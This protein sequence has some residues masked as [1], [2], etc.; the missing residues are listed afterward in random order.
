MLNNFLNNTNNWRA[1]CLCKMA[2]FC[3]NSLQDSR[4]VSLAH[5]VFK[6]IPFLLLLCSFE[7]FADVL[8]L[9][10][11]ATDDYASVMVVTSPSATGDLSA[12]D[13]YGSIVT[14]NGTTAGRYGFLQLSGSS[15]SYTYTLYDNS[16]NS[17]LAAGQVVTDIFTYTYANNVGQ[18][19]SARLIVQVTGNPPTPTVPVAVDDYASVMVGT[20]PSAT[21]NLS[22]NDRYGSIVTVNGTTAG[23]YGF[24]QLS[25][26]SGSYTYTLYNNSANSALA[27]GQVVTDT[28]TYTYANTGGQSATARLIVQV[29]GNP[30]IPVAVD[31]YAS[32]IVGTSPFLVGNLSANDLYCSIVTINGSTTGRYGFLQLTNTGGSYAYTL[33]TNSANSALAGGQVV[34]DTFTYT[35][36]NTV[37]Q[38][39]SARLIVQV[40]GP[41]TSTVPVAVDDYVTV[42]S[43]LVTTTINT[44]GSTK[45]NIGN[46]TVAGNVSTNDQNWKF[47]SLNSSPTSQ[48]GFLTGKSDGSFIYTVYNNAPGI[49]A[50]T[51]GQVVIDSFSYNAVDQYGQTATAKL[52]VT[53]IGNPVDAYGNTVFNNNP[54]DNV[55]IEPND[56]FRSATPLN[57]A[58]NIKGSL[59]RPGDKDWYLL[60]SDGNEIITVNV[61]P[62]GSSCF[63]QKNWELY[64]FDSAK[65]TDAM[66]DPYNSYVFRHWLD[67]TGSTVDLSG[68]D[69]SKTDIYGKPI[70]PSLNEAILP[71]PYFSDHMYLA[72]YAG[73]YNGA[74]IGIVDPC[75]NPSN[76]LD[77]G[78]GPGVRDFFIAI[79][80]TLQGSDDTGKPAG[81]CGI[82]RPILLK[83][84]QSV[85]G[86]D[87]STPPAS[88]LY[89][90]TE[91]YYSVFPYNSGQYTINV[92]GTGLDP[93]LST[94]ALA[95]SAT[96]NTGTGVL[97]IPKIR[98]VD[99]L[100]GANLTRQNQAAGSSSYKFDLLNLQ[101]L[102]FGVVADAFQ[103]TYNPVNQQVMI[104]RLTTDTAGK[105][106]YAVILQYHP[107]AGGNFAWL[108]A[109][110]ITP[111]QSPIQ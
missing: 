6:N 67:A 71:S 33:Y 10:P 39:A 78:V 17:A 89:T 38:S 48:Y 92:T 62:Q 91:E 86:W 51:A 18:S 5:R 93:L 36:A 9:P 29:T 109:I 7:L 99:K 65:L 52:N 103:A 13:R 82:N 24:L 96:Y 79:S 94:K 3:A 59:Y 60:H 25:G 80:S 15:G 69:L 72:Y 83:A 95:G 88:K 74:L 84:G 50:L 49:T 90:T 37:G 41:S 107:E 8:R 85:S 44:D 66:E 22:A 100:Y 73:T 20:S 110:K 4:C 34:T 28:F 14:I 64:V 97:N 40:T 43:N 87:A 70:P 102:G 63:G 11:Q 21:G 1:K 54:F 19:A 106:A 104:P 45:V 2:L 42:L 61:C 58:R 47:F 31:D 12:N 32:A 108:E 30:T 77:I 35:C 27:A 56:S 46:A 98:I 81:K 101:E 105:N 111:I 23:R 53:I 75:F 68:T 16:T 76:S 57:S 55:D 26:S